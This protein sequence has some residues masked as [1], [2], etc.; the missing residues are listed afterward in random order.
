MLATFF[1][2]A[3][4]NWFLTH[5]ALLTFRDTCVLVTQ[6][7]KLDA[8]TDRIPLE[9]KHR[10]HRLYLYPPTALFKCIPDQ[11]R[12]ITVPY[13]KLIAV[14]HIG[15]LKG[16]LTDSPLENVIS[17]ST[18]AFKAGL[19]HSVLGLVRLELHSVELVRELIGHRLGELNELYVLAAW[20]S[21]L[22]LRL[23]SLLLLEGVVVCGRGAWL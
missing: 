23:E 19:G 21:L 11:P 4:F 12:V 20:E 14:L 22:E 8:I 6:S 1:R 18:F 10:M 7:C 15:I 9:I 3:L 2:M 17:I 13:D 16:D 5:C